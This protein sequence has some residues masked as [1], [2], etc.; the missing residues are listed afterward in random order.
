MPLTT[1]TDITPEM[2]HC[3]VCHGIDWDDL[4]DGC[5]VCDGWRVVEAPGWVWDGG[6][7]LLRPDAAL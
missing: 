5:E 2:V 1:V 3:P 6:R 4:P 7:W